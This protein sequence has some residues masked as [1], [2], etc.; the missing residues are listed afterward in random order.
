MG[1]KRPAK[2]IK[3]RQDVL[4]IQ[5]YLLNNANTA[6]LGERNKMIFLIGTTTGYRAGDLVELKK[7]DVKEALKR[8]EFLIFE[9]KKKKSKNIR[10]ANRKPREAVLIPKVAKLLSEYTK[11]MKEYEYI[12][13]SR[14]GVNKHIGVPAISKELKKAGKYFGLED[15]TA[16]SMRKTYA[17]KIYKENNNDILL[18]K[19]MLGHSSVEET[20]KYLG[21]DKERY[22]NASQTLSDFVG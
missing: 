16:H 21:L 15:I 4:D 14:K 13:K 11:D 19:E 10:E 1:K 18:V 20:K 2:P 3:R 8:G 9:N 7:R 12:F 22:H 17:Y 6:E 5:D